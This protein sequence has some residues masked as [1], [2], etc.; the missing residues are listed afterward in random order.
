MGGAGRGECIFS[1][2][3]SSAHHGTELRA[4]EEEEETRRG[5]GGGEGSS[6][7]DGL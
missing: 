3:S 2:L 1:F 5:R 6:I 7:R 4:R